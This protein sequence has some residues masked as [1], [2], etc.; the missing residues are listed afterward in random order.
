MTKYLKKYDTSKEGSMTTMSNNRGISQ[1]VLK[2]LAIDG[3]TKYVL[4]KTKLSKGHLGKT[5]NRLLKQGKINRIS[6]GVYEV[7]Q[8]ALGTPQEVRHFE[9]KIDIFRLHNLE[10]KLRISKDVHSQIKN[11]VFSDI[12]RYKVR[13]QTQYAHYFDLTD[14]EATGLITTENIF[15]FMP[16]EY[17][18]YGESIAQCYFILDQEIR[19]ILLKWENIF[20]ITLWKQGR[21]NY[22]ITNQ[23]LAISNNPVA[24]EYNDDKQGFVSVKDDEDG[25]VA[26]QID[27]SLL[28]GEIESPHSTKAPSY[29][30]KAKFLLNQV[31]TGEF[32]LRSKEHDDMIILVKQNTL[33]IHTL[34]GLTKP[35]Q[36]INEPTD[37]KDQKIITDY[38]G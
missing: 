23:H 14:S 15:I 38:I 9:D 36:P 24:K 5:L 32:E 2:L 37:N 35:N 1:K 33:L 27:K 10:L 18:I 28:S 20:K 13:N 30:E 4:R 8:N 31:K 25:K 21:V 22:E 17:S 12:V 7:R 19:K 11:I 29:A 6:R 26:L 16:K 34:Y 3:T